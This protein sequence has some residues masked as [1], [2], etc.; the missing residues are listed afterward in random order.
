LTIE[1]K[2]EIPVDLRPL[3]G[4]WVFGC[5]ICQQVCPWN[6]FAPPPDPAFTSRSGQSRPSLAIDLALNATEF[7]HK[8]KDSPILRA[9]RRGYLRNLAVSLGNSSTPSTSPILKR[10]LNDSETLLHEHAAWALA[11]LQTKNQESK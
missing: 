5:D 7:K 8:F 1:N 2:G 6:R 9:K 10:L 11:R 4:D 3:L